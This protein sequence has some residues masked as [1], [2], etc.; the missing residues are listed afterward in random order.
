MPP[1]PGS[2]RIAAFLLLA[3][4]SVGCGLGADKPR[5]LAE[6]TGRQL[7]VIVQSSPVDPTSAQLEV[8][9]S[10]DHP[11]GQCFFVRD[12]TG[13]LNGETSRQH[14][15]YSTMGGGCAFPR[16]E[17][18]LPPTNPANPLGHFVLS[19]ATLEIVMDMDTL[20]APQTMSLRPPAMANLWATE[21]VRIDLSPADGVTDSSI[22]FTLDGQAT[23]SFAGDGG[24][25]P[26]GASLPF[27]VPAGCPSGA[28]TLRLATDGPLHVSTCSGVD[29][30]DSFLS[31][32]RTLAV[33]LQG[34]SACTTAADCHGGLP[35]CDTSGATC[36]V[37]LTDADCPAGIPCETSGTHYCAG[38]PPG[39]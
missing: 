6:L 33:T 16:W 12:P 8:T 15:G 20:L 1:A 5:D 17:F 30:C 14:D 31:H 9:L 27:W 32:Q 3:S 36:A 35:F 4:A 21:A 10:F 22:D 39:P 38:T 2:G 11:A 26:D 19:D 25:G 18:A 34:P 29:K 13:E 7:F 28:G 23:P 24:V 37:C